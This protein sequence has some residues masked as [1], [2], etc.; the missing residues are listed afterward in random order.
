MNILI[1]E[2]IG[3]NIQSVH[4]LKSMQIDKYSLSSNLISSS[5]VGNDHKTW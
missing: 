4:Q 5:E 3:R 1:F 2:P